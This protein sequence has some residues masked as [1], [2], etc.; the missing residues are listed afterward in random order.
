MGTNYYTIKRCDHCHHEERL[1]VG[2]SSYGWCFALATHPS[3]GIASLDD[4]RRKFAEVG[5]SIVNEYEEPVTVDEMLSCVTAREGSG[6]K[7]SDFAGMGVQGPNGLRRSTVDG[8]HCIA[9]G[10]GTWYIM[11]GEFS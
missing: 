7:Y 6:R 5:V 1:H 3:I 2:R 8:R 9:H 4:W 10:T 11:R